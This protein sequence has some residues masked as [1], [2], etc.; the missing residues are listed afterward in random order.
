MRSGLGERVRI[1]SVL[2]VAMGVSSTACR[3]TDT[4]KESD[5]QA[6]AAQLVLPQKTADASPETSAP[7]SFDVDEKTGRTKSTLVLRLDHFPDPKPGVTNLP[8]CYA[9]FPEGFEVG[10]AVCDGRPDVRIPVFA[11][12][13]DQDCYTNPSMQRVS[14]LQPLVLPGCRKGGLLVHAYDP[15]LKV[16][17]EVRDVN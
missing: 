16:D 13:V 3:R 7:L 14:A 2:V 15:R 17:L 6:A 8:V 1:A 9:P 4:R 12:N 10:V 11:K 5:N